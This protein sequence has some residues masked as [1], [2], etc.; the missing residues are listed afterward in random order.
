MGRTV[1]IG[2]VGASYRAMHGFMENLLA[3]HGGTHEIVGVFDIDEGRVRAV[4]EQLQCGAIPAY[5]DLDEMI[6]ET[7][8]E[9]VVI[10][11]PDASHAD[12]LSRCFERGVD[13][14]VEKPLC[15]DAAQCRQILEV[16]RRFPERKAV[17]AH[18]VRYSPRST[19]VKD[20]IEDGAVGRILSIGYVV[21]LSL[22]DGASYCHRW[23]G[24]K[25]QSGG[26]LIHKACHD[27]DLINWLVGSRATRLVAQGGQHLFGPANSPFRGE[28]CGTCP[29]A[30]ECRWYVDVSRAGVRSGLYHAANRSPLDYAPDLCVFSPDMDAEDNA[31]VAYTYENGVS[32]AFD[33]CMYATKH[34]RRGITIQGSEG[35]LEVL[36]EH[37]LRLTR[38]GREPEEIVVPPSPGGH[39]GA[40]P[41]MVRDLFGPPTQ[42]KTM[43]TL[44]DGIQA[45]LIGAAANIAIAEGRSVDV[46]S[47]LK[48]GIMAQNRR[49]PTP[50]YAT[51]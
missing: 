34:I 9:T 15:I 13:A 14:V 41:R 38:E 28:R 45:V 51:L 17:T 44:V 35:A 7:R 36:S 43:A 16:S 8:P 3:N 2:F 10:A 18:N 23:N 42:S 11:T 49:R 12:Y 46:Q 5:T 48:S 6:R 25:N 1:R 50:G 29:H 37:R 19:K 32:V 47:L 4:A 33:F 24:R 26:L 22:G 20:M 27:F 31:V 30:Q 39:H 21:R 40:D